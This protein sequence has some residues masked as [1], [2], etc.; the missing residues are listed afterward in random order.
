MNAPNRWHVHLESK[1][2]YMNVLIVT[3]DNLHNSVVYDVHLIAENL[4][5][6]D[7]KVFTLSSQ[8]GKG[9]QL[10]TKKRRLNRVNPNST[11]SSI[12]VGFINMPFL[13][14]LYFVI[15]SFIEMEKI[16]RKEKIDI[17]ILY[18]VLLSSMPVLILSKI[19]KTPVVFRNIDMLHKL[20]QV[21]FKR[22][23]VKYLERFVYRKVDYILS[24]SNK[25]TEY[26]KKMG[27]LDKKM[28]LLPFPVN[29][30]FFN[31][32]PQDEQI[33]KEWRLS[34]T[35]F[36]I[37]FV[38]YLYRFNGLANLIGNLTELIESQPKI[39]MLIVGD[40]PLRCSIENIISHKELE[41]NVILTG[42][43][44]Y[45]MIPKLINLADICINVYQ[46]TGEMK[47]L[48]CAKI[49]QY[50]AC[51]KPTVSTALN[52]MMDMIPGKG[53]CGVLYSNDD[54][55][56][57]KDIKFLISSNESRERIGRDGIE[58][59]RQ[60]HDSAKIIERI[61]CILTPIIERQKY[62]T[63]KK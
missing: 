28:E 49:I 38:G 11:V 27:A 16:L 17:I 26:L 36:I 33:Y 63:D 61:E 43:Q 55:E 59:V 19:Y 60:Q 12:N 20:I 40:G 23:I 52:G 56:M 24:L 48:F 18:S 31:K 62:S 29:M 7:H 42:M 50:L 39:K 22:K 41:N 14:S 1:K 53:K 3:D 13:G 9:A 37:V 6:R 45:D 25:Y 32:A 34:D 21:S 58:F 30:E 4:S 10:G 15:Q 8:C 51:G 57:I 46:K 5:L 44:P 47:D 2:N 35:D 54:M